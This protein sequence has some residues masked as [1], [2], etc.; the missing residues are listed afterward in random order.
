MNIN[1]GIVGQGF[2]GTAVREGLKKHFNIQ[3]Y[4]YDLNK[5]T[6][7]TLEDLVNKK[8]KDR[9]LKTS[10]KSVSEIKKTSTVHPTPPILTNCFIKNDV[11]R[12][13]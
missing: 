6:C 3:T 11:V 10:G 7:N 1:I 12:S 8:R 4:D 2:V 9:K 5:A 13:P